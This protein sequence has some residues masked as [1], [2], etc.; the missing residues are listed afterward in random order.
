V[1]DQILDIVGVIETNPTNPKKTQASPSPARSFVRTFAR[2]CRVGKGVPSLI[3][4][5]SILALRHI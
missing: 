4:C 2:V 5:L 3:R 1:L